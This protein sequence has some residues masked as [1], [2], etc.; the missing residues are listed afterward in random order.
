MLNDIKTEYPTLCFIFYAFPLAVKLLIHTDILKDYTCVV[1]VVFSPCG[2]VS[3][4]LPSSQKEPI[5]FP[6]VC[7]VY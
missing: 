3:H 6:H 5:Q 1:C 4:L 7:R 2:I